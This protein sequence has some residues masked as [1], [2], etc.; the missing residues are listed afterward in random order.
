MPGLVF[1]EILP[2]AGT[3][4]TFALNFGFNIGSAAYLQDHLHKSSS[5]VIGLLKF[6]SPVLL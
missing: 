1:E 6:N 2:V 5:K 3:A 4:E